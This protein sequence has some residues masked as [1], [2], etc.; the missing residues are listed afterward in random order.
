M[1]PKDIT[2]WQEDSWGRDF[3]ELSAHLEGASD[4]TRQFDD[5]AQGHIE[6]LDIR[7]NLTTVLLQIDGAR[8]LARRFKS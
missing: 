1:P 2:I 3:S 6:S 5:W 8:S 4:M 7:E